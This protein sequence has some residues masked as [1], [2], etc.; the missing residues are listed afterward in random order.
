MAAGDTP[1]TFVHNCTAPV[2]R[3][4]LAP[5]AG[6]KAE[7]LVHDVLALHH[8]TTKSQEE[9]MI[10]M[11]RGSGM[12]RQRCVARVSLGCWLC[13]LIGIGPPACYHMSH[14]AH[15][16]NNSH[17]LVITYLNHCIAAPQGLGVLLVCGQVERGLQFDALAVWDDDVAFQPLLGPQALA[18]QLEQYE[19]E[20]HENFW[21]KAQQE[22]QKQ[23]TEAA[24]AAANAE[25]QERQE[26]GGA[27]GGDTDRRWYRRF[28]T[29]SQI[30]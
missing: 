3:T 25:E 21:G 27:A 28:T 24:A 26:G 5:V 10:K 1:H 15:L 2:V 19:S 30:M 4:N 13:C 16:A 12:K 20:E 6:Q 17:S 11:A 7:D 18:A 14:A 8:Y 9:F 22:R 29:R 23:R